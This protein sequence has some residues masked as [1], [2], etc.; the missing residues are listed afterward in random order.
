MDTYAQTLCIHFRSR[1]S[2][3]RARL[4]IAPL[5]RDLRAAL[6]TRMDDNNTNALRVLRVMRRHGQRGT[7]FLNHPSHWWEDGPRRGWQRLAD[8]GSLVPARILAAGSSIG[9]H[10]LSHD[11]LPALSKHAAFREIMGGRIAL[12]A[13]TRSEVSTFTFPFVCY[14]SGLR[15]GRDRADLDQMLQRAGFLLV[16]EDGYTRRSPP[17]LLDAAFIDCDGSH[18]EDGIDE[19]VVARQLRPGRRPLLLV[20]MH[21]WIRAWGGRRF[22][23]LDQLYRKWSRRP[24]WWYCNQNQYAAYRW[25]AS[26]S[27]IE[28]QVAGDRMAVTLTRPD[29][30]D[31]MACVP[32]TL[33][34]GGVAEDEVTSVTSKDST[35]APLSLQGRRALDV[36]HPS[37]RGPVELFGESANDDNRGR[38][39]R[40]QPSTGHLQALLSRTGTTLTLKLRNAGSGPITRLRILFR[41]PLNWETGRVR[42]SLERL[43]PGAESTIKV[44][45]AGRSRGAEYQVG[46]E[47]NVAQI[48]FTGN[49]RTRLY[50]TCSVPGP[51]PGPGFARNGFR[52]MGPLPEEANEDN[53]HLPGESG[54]RPSGQ[55]LTWR[56]LDADRAKGLDPDIIPIGGRPRAADSHPSPRNPGA[57]L[58][59]AVWGYA[60]SKA[61]QVVTAIF[62]G[63]YV[64]ALKLNGRR[65]RGRKLSLKKGLNELRMIYAPPRALEALFSEHHYGCYFRL[66]NADG[67]RAPG[68]RFVPPPGTTGPRRKRPD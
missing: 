7:F 46:T 61:D 31:L 42:R 39:S 30:L 3:Q 40:R 6:S 47:Y 58:R 49:V 26:G 63:E 8:P 13:K 66:T 67:R 9:A 15:G 55:A 5:Y 12:E 11:H 57:R 24:D 33:V 41:L 22:T 37:D 50:A 16:G 2:A 21:A 65:V 27:K 59:Y 28:T 68:V 19:R 53:P 60:A 54:P 51:E 29:P 44:R 56:T 14:Q 17:G 1:R 23:T 52:F 62:A 35:F 36:F 25:Q 32:L 48:D 4:R 20:T 64:S 45:L 38:F 18:A 43:E 34:I 10:T